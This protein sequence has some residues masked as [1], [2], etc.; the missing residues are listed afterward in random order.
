VLVG[1]GVPVLLGLGVTLLVGVAD[2]VGGGGS[3]VGVTVA[4]AVAVGVAL[5]VGS[6]VGVLVG[7][8]LCMGVGL[9]VDFGQYSLT[10]AGQPDHAKRTVLNSSALALDTLTAS[11]TTI[12]AGVNPLISEYAE[13]ARKFVR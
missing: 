10:L 3:T 12:K 5:G 8:T 6:P 13:A 7:T 1:P 9:S 2:G 11:V 4:V